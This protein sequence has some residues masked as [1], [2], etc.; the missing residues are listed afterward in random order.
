M[1]LKWHKSGDCWY[2]GPFAVGPTYDNAMYVLWVRRRECWFF[3]F[4][5]N[6]KAA[7]QRIADAALR[8]M[9]EWR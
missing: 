7:A 3:R 9:K 6:A 2:A 4:L 8:A 1:K 5:H